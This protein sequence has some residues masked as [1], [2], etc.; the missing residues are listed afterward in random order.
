MSTAN[1][2]LSMTSIP[3]RIELFLASLDWLTQQ[4]VLPKATV[5]WLGIEHF[6][7]AR[8]RDLRRFRLPPGV[9]IRYCRDV[10]PHTKLIYA[11]R[12]WR[13]TPIVTADDDVLYPPFW[14]A[15]LYEAYRRAPG[16]I[17]CFRAHEMR[18]AADGRPI[19]YMEWGWG[20]PGLAGPSRLLFATG[21]SG[22]IYP[23][24]SLSS[25][26]FDVDVMRALCPTADDIWFKAMSLLAATAVQKVRATSLDFPQIPGTDRRALWPV[27]FARNHIQLQQVFDYYELYDRLGG[28]D[29]G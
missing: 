10:G 15:E 17:H 8:R 22:V 25:H 11:L 27:N 14:L 20:A 19:P 13:D 12:E 21:T 6:A 4:T 2:V 18:L 7:A 24:A 26:V 28:V 9:E 23:P 16:H 1:V 29:A 3:D 5:I